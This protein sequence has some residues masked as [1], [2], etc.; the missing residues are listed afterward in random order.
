MFEPDQ[1]GARQRADRQGQTQ[2]GHDLVAAVYG[3]FTEGTEASRPTI[4]KRP[5]Q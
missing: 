4:S 5:G 2:A 3:S 1:H